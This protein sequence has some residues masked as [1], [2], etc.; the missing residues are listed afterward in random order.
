MLFYCSVF[1]ETA[2]YNFLFERASL[3]MFFI[4]FRRFRRF[5]RIDLA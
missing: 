2:D 1:F 5:R 3:D 4:A